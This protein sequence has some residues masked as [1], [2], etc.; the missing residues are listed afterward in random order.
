MALLTLLLAATLLG[1]FALYKYLESCR[2]HRI[3]TGLKPLPG[4]KGI[5]TSP[6]L[7]T[8]II[9]LCMLTDDDQA[10][11]SLGPSLMYPKRMPS[12]SSQTG[13]RSTAPSTRLTWPAPTTS[14]CRLRRSPTTFYQR[15]L[16]STPTAHISP[17]CSTTTAPAHSISPYSAEMVRFNILTSC[18]I[19]NTFKRATRASESSPTSSCGN[20][21]K[22]LSTATPS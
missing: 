19:T 9:R 14:G 17:P 20:P 13:V 4:P 3:P 6:L 21:K 5:Y 10:I 12:S 15:K 16:P 18:T 11:P 7:F 8:A 2:L 1:A 22:H